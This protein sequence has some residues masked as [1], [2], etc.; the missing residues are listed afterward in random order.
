MSRGLRWLLWLVLAM[1]LAAALGGALL[2][3]TES[4]RGVLAGWI[5]DFTTSKIPGSMKIG[6]LESIGFLHP[7]ATDIA[8]FTPDGERVLHVEKA[9]VHWDVQ[10]LFKGKIG[11]HM[12]RADH[13]ELVIAIDENGTTNLEHAFKKDQEDK[14]DL[15]LESMHFENMTVVL[16]MGGETR[17]VVR[18]VQGFI[19]VWRRGTPGVRVDIG[20]VRGV[21]EK[22]EITGDAIELLQMKGQV[23]AR[24]HHVASLTLETRIGK[25]GI[26]AFFD[27]YEREEAPAQLKLR[28]DTGSGARIAAFA[29]EVRSWFSDKLDVTV[30][31]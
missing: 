11:F 23:W 24:E 22:P 12:A 26:D 13:G 1:A 25:G 21:F 16:R 6:K 18:D 19:S 2:V 8:F 5:A 14:V 10:E 31:N 4:G 15:A 3:W 7:V 20:R 27:Y 30:E 28:P 29:I 9:Q 17:F